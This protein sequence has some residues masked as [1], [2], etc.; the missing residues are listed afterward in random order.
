MAYGHA[1][2]NLAL[3]R[4]LEAETREL[5]GSLDQLNPE[6]SAW[7]QDG[8]QVARQEIEQGPCSHEVWPRLSPGSLGSRLDRLLEQFELLFAWSA[9]LKIRKLA[10]QVRA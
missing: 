1:E 5:L 3:I 10:L 2:R 9:R 4:K 8:C 6:Q 7:L